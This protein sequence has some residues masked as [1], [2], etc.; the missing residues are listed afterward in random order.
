MHISLFCLY[1]KIAIRVIF[2]NLEEKAL[3]TQLKY[4]GRIVDVAVSTALLPNG[5]TAVREV[6]R[7]PGGVAV[8]PV[9]D[10][11]DALLVRQ[12]RFPYGEELLEIPAGKMDRGAET[13]LECGRRELLEETG[14]SA[15]QMIYL[16]AMYPSPGFL[17][18]VIHLYFAKDLIQN[19]AMPDEDEFVL[20]QRVP[21]NELKK[22]IAGDQIRDAK[23]NAA[24]LR[25]SLRSLI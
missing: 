22:M 21:V 14:L 16:G 5:R 20:C 2:L 17:D 19:E 3:D 10:N 18:E 12:Y 25:A 13:H 23:T 6:C 8:L 11:G 9:F 1:G 7:H 15:G 24:V 4:R